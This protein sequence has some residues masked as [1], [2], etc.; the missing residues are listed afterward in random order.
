MKRFFVVCLCLLTVSCARNDDPV[1]RHAGRWLLVNYWAEWCKPCREE[2]RELN[3]FASKHKAT[4]S[5]AGVNFDGISGD[6]LQQQAKTLGISFELMTVDPAQLG[7][8]PKPEVLPTTQIVDPDGKLVQTL[9][10]PQT[11]ESLTKALE[12]AQRK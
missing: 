6:A 11:Q 2:I 12:T 5:V 4:T 10:G 3:A 9:V 8:W 7:H 1:A